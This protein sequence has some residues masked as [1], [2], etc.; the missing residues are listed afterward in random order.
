MSDISAKTK[1]ADQEKLKNE[2][3][4]MIEPVVRPIARAA[5]ERQQEMQTLLDE[6]S[7]LGKTFIWVLAML[8]EGYYKIEDGKLLF[9]DSG[10]LMLAES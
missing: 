5:L 1:E 4:A 8:K 7:P 9:A 2:I 3:K 10:E 6:M